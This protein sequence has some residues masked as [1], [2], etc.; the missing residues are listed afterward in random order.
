MFVSFPY[1]IF[2]E[3]GMKINDATDKVNVLS[4]SNANGSDGYFVTRDQL[5]MGGYETDMF[6]YGDVQNFTDDADFYVIQET[7]KNLEDLI[8]T[9]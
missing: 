7:L 9:E 5:Y 8:C 2:C 4:L 3:I 6:L 1:E